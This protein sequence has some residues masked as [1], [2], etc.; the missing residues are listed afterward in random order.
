MRRVACSCGRGLTLFID[1]TRRITVL[2]LQEGA[3]HP[4]GDEHVGGQ[5]IEWNILDVGFALGPLERTVVC[6]AGPYEPMFAGRP[7]SFG[8]RTF[9]SR[10]GMSFEPGPNQR[11]CAYPIT[12]G[13]GLDRDGHVGVGQHCP[14]APRMTRLSGFERARGSTPGNPGAHAKV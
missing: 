11:R 6:S 2:S 13:A 7:L 14:N 4:I 1:E 12:P 8:G 10:F 5:A 9:W 3:I